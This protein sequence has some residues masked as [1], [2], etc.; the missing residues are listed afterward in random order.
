[1]SFR[2]RTVLL[3][4]VGL[5]LVASR[6]Y[7]VEVLWTDDFQAYTGPGEYTQVWYD[8]STDADPGGI[9]TVGTYSSPYQ[10]PHLPSVQVMRS[11]VPDPANIPGYGYA[12]NRGDGDQFMHTISI[13]GGPPTVAWASIPAAAQTRMAER[14]HM[15]LEFDAYNCV[16]TEGGW[17]NDIELM[18]YDAPHM[19]ITNWCFSLHLN[20][21]GTIEY[22]D[23]DT[24]AHPSPPGSYPGWFELPELSAVYEPN[25]WQHVTFDIDF[26]TDRAAVTIDDVTVGDLKFQAGDLDKI[27]TLALWV[28][29][30]GGLWGRAAFDN[31]RLS[32]IPEPSSIALLAIGLIGLIGCTWRRRR[33]CRHNH[34][35]L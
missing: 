14:G 15:R 23:G 21:D 28:P 5:A 32:I 12:I 25:E 3:V 2:S 9:W 26:R 10:E 8:G 33:I 17:G 34:R 13:S 4:A 7:A 19:G 31:F 30:G 24:G 1:M 22:Y 11:P 16:T 27:Q 6:A 20:R 29:S 18:G 35:A